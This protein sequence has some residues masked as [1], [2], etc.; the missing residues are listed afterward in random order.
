MKHNNK[1]KI[2]TNRKLNKRSTAKTLLKYA[3]TWK[4]NDFEKCLELV[5]KTRAK[6]SFNKCKF[7]K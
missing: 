2:K 4:G 7:N 5:Y 6:A 1:A 3:G